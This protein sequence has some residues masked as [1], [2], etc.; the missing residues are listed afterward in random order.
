MPGSPSQSQPAAASRSDGRLAA[1]LALSAGALAGATN[2]VPAA[3]VHLDLGDTQVGFGGAADFTLDLPG[4]NDAVFE[5][6][7]NTD[8]STTAR[9]VKFRP[10]NLGAL[11]V[12]VYSNVGTSFFGY[13]FGR[14]LAAN[15]RWGTITDPERSFAYVGVRSEFQ[16]SVVGPGSFS[17][18]YYA[19]KFTNTAAGNQTRFGWIKLS[20]DISDTTGP[21][22]T[23]H[24]WAYDDSGAEILTGVPEPRQ[25]ALAMGAALVLGAAGLRAWRKRKQT[26]ATAG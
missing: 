7:T 4:T 22:V 8:T 9:F 20:M 12:K 1:L 2:S 3:I 26:R 11:Q 6:G 23:L 17:D 16:A 18:R 21:L 24:E 5:R 15:R 10:L 25:S 14:R 19:F 13:F